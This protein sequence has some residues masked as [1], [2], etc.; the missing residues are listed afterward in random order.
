MARITL[1]GDYTQF[2]IS[3]NKIGDCVFDMIEFIEDED[4]ET[5][6]QYIVSKKDIPRII[7]ILE[8]IQQVG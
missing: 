5:W 6:L 7:K 8:E 1:Y 4:E 2:T 3:N